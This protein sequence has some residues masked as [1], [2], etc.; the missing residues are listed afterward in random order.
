MSSILEQLEEK[1]RLANKLFDHLYEK[2]GHYVNAASWLKSETGVLS[3]QSTNELTYLLRSHE[4]ARGKADMH[5]VV[6]ITEFGVS[7]KEKHSSYLEYLRLLEQEEQ[8][9]REREEAQ[10]QA[11]LITLSAHELNIENA[12]KNDRD[13]R[14]IRITIMINLGILALQLVLIAWPELKHILIVAL[15][16]LI[17]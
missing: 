13:K 10:H 12:K 17:S 7:T 5:H 11:N 15:K 3:E 8:R 4:L 2:R 1:K 16:G 14:F 6:V 9:K